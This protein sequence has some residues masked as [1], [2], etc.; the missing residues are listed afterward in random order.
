MTTQ[1]VNLNTINQARIDAVNGKPVT[2]MWDFSSNKEVL[3]ERTKLMKNRRLLIFFSFLILVLQLFVIIT[4]MALV[5]TNEIDFIALDASGKY[6]YIIMM[7]MGS[8]NMI[9]GFLLTYGFRKRT[10]ARKKGDLDTFTGIPSAISGLVIFVY[11]ITHTI[12]SMALMINE[13]EPFFG[14]MA[15]EVVFVV[16]IILVVI[17]YLGVL[18]GILLAMGIRGEDLAE[19]RT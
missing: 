11:G 17:S 19:P 13:S 10:I 5:F 2:K 1:P 4:Q 9:G 18:G 7:I 15:T 12:V 8:L 16:L 6:W 3:V 14:W